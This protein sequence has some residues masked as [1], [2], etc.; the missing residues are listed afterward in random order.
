MARAGVFDEHEAGAMY[1]IF[2]VLS[3]VRHLS[4][5]SMCDMS[6]AS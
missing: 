3:A 2:G 1:T 6:A 4:R 5:Q